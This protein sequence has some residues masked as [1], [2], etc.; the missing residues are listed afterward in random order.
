MIMRH[1]L[2]DHARAKRAIRRGGPHARRTQLDETFMLFEARSADLLAVEA[3]LE[4]LAKRDERKARIVEL[5]FFGGLSNEEVARALG[6]SE[7][8]VGREWQFARSW[9]HAELSG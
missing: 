6:I 2:V 5:R 8:T 7:R 4:R 3:A 1:V 9:L